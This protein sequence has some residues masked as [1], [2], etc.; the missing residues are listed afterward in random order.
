MTVPV[1][2]RMKKK[3]KEIIKVK[4]THSWLHTFMSEFFHFSPVTLEG[5]K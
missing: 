1:A 4:Q 5:I 3:R 2:G